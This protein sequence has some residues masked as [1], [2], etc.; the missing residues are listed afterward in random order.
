M[1]SNLPPGVTD[2]DIDAGWD[3]TSECVVCREEFATDSTVEV[4]GVCGYPEQAIVCDDCVEDHKGRMSCY[5]DEARLYVEEVDNHPRIQ[6]I[7]EAVYRYAI[8]NPESSLTA[9]VRK[10]LGYDADYVCCR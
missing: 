9:M 3:G 5:H 10:E 7:V 8:D 2:A 6:R 1:S 4:C